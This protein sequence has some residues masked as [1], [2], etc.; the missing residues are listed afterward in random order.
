MTKRQSVKLL[1]ELMVDRSNYA[2][3]MRFVSDEN[4]L[5]LVMN[6]LRDR[7]RNIQYEAFH[8]FKVFVANP[9][10]TPRVE[11]ILRRNRERLLAYLADFSPERDC[12]CRADQ[13]T[14]LST[15]SSMSCTLS[16]MSPPLTRSLRT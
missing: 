2:V 11:A 15:R 6:L 3:M 12:A 1:A 13:P 7:S 5:K 9:K 4:N 8:V 14:L 10:K 16:S